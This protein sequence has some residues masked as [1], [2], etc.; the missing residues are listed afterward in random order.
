MLAEPYWRVAPADTFAGGVSGNETL[1]V[2]NHVVLLF[3][4][5]NHSYPGIEKYLQRFSI[6]SVRIPS[7]DFNQ[8]WDKLFTNGAL[9]VLEEIRLLLMQAVPH[10]NDEK[11]LQIVIPGELSLYRG[12]AAMLRTA[13]LENPFF[14][15]QVIEILNETESEMLANM[16]V[17]NRD[18]PEHGLIRYKSTPGQ[19][20]I[21]LR[22]VQDWKM[23]EHDPFESAFDIPWKPE[24]VYVITGEQV[25][26]GL[27]WLKK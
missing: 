21:G 27:S 14:H 18:Y 23:I 22:H 20:G 5:S 7:T 25:L 15:G 10:V 12:I 8:S 26:S 1:T 13:E 24:G 16:L 4:D 6:Q 19:S 17:D 11:W 3:E 9:R 2:D